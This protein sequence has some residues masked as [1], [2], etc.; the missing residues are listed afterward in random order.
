MI[1]SCIERWL[2]KQIEAM[3]GKLFK[4][5]SPGN[6]GVPDRILILPGGVIKFIE[7]KTKTGRL[8]PIQTYIHKRLRDLGCDVV[9]VYGMDGAAVLVEYLRQELRRKEARQVEVHPAQLSGK[10]DAEDH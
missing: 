8:L 5:V 4:W 10:S 3:G 1:E 9:T 7:L 6:D 2:R